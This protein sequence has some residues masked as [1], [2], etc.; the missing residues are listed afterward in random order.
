MSRIGTPHTSSQGEIHL[1]CLELALWQTKSTMCG[2]RSGGISHGFKQVSTDFRCSEQSFLSRKSQTMPDMVNFYSRVCPQFCKKGNSKKSLPKQS[3]R[4]NDG[5][6]WQQ[7]NA[8]WANMQWNVRVWANCGNQKVVHRTS[9][10]VV[11]TLWLL[12]CW[13]GSMVSVRLIKVKGRA[14][15]AVPAHRWLLELSS[16]PSW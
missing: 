6:T 11:C 8:L 7:F 12:P 9:F 2:D 3:E 13:F 16:A 4:P 1:D 14:I 15:E 10:Y 5:S